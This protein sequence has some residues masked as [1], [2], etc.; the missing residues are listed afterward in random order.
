[1]V[2][3]SNMLKKRPVVAILLILLAGVIAY[4]N[5][6]HV[7]F[8]LDDQSSIV[9][10][11]VIRNLTNFYTNR[12]GF[13]FTPSR[14]VAY[15]S[16]ALNYH[17]GG[18]HVFGYHL[19]NLILHLL[20]G[21]LVY[22][23]VRL[24][25]CTFFM[26][27]SRLQ[28]RRNGIA[29][30]AALLFVVHP[31][32]TQAV[33]YIVQRMTSLTALFYLLSLVLYVLARLGLE[34]R[35]ARA[36]G[37]RGREPDGEQL[38]AA[39]GVRVRAGLLI[40]GAVVAAALA[41]LTKPIAFTLPFAILLYEIC[42]F[43]GPWRRRLAFLVP[44]L[45]TIPIVPLAVFSYGG[46]SS[47]I[48]LAAAPQAHA[49]GTIPPR[50][51]YLY[52]QFRVIVTYLRLLVLPVNQNLD[53]DY[54]IYST[55][56]TPPVFL[57]FLLLVAII[58]LAAYLLWITGKDR[59]NRVENGAGSG[60]SQVQGTSGPEESSSTAVA[61]Q[62]QPASS[63]SLL[64]DPAARLIA[65]GIFWFFLA[66]S[67][68]SSLVPIAD[69][70]MEHRLYL[71]VFGAATAFSTFGFWMAER[72]AR[73][74]GRRLLILAAAILVLVFGIATVRRNQTWG[75]ET[76]LWQ[77]T[78]TKSPQKIRVY[79][80]LGLALTHAGRLPEAIDVLSRGLALDPL[81]PLIDNNLAMAYILNN[82]SNMALPLLK[83]AI[84]LDPDYLDA[85]INLAAAYNQLRRF[86]DTVNFLEQNWG[87]LKERVDAHYHLG[88]A[89]A[90]L[91][92]LQGARRELAI[93]SRTDPALAADLL[94]LLN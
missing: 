25:F 24:T 43:G 71:P 6:F 65:F 26:R 94:R 46:P 47:G 11:V 33:T 1:M 17:Y 13:E 15:L 79:N 34:G 59:V 3:S 93:V 30:L 5:T 62:P 80:N 18:L 48:L 78:L 41:M 10:N 76:R 84:G 44:M 86:H 16:F 39:S 8:M 21:I 69:V 45:A 12:T 64:A 40:A 53:Y 4:A 32:Q 56:F 60:K 66:L 67:V 57:S 87:R 73:P 63:S 54:P 77:D 19:V 88:V 23:L 58:A 49:I 2:L 42:F 82:Q 75:N 29:L 22:T 20:A 74:A 31:V 92:D 70:I 9:K 14:Y 50:L 81:Y 91:G 52:T 28:P 36:T 7:P 68:E 35:A 55:F 38:P 61:A 72:F 85:Y 37:T 90:F 89:K 83:G 27:A 51:D